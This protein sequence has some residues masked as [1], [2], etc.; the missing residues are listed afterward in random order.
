MKMIFLFQDSQFCESGKNEKHS[1]FV[2][3][4]VVAR[5]PVPVC[6]DVND[7]GLHFYSLK[8]EKDDVP[9]MSRSEF[10]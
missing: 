4:R 1:G 8:E 3:L 5:F 7:C 6:Y 2:F 10:L 9:R